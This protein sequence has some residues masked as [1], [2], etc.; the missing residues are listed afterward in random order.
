MSLNTILSEDS[1]N[2]NPIIQ[3]DN[4]YKEHLASG[5]AI[6]NSVSLGTS[7]PD[8]KVSLRTVL[9]KEYGE[10][11][12]VF[13]TNYESKKGSQLAANPNVA[14]LF[15]WHESGRQVRIEGVAEKISSQESDSY[16]STRPRESQLSAWASKQSTAVPGRHYLEERHEYYKQLFSDRNVDRPPHWGGFL[17]TPSWFEFWQNDERRLHDR[18]TYTKLNKTWVLERLAP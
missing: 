6:P 15:Y 12:F 4:W 18:L 8:G 2:Q 16:F 10:N 11:G 14:L 1:V 7:T 9:L 17:I 3:F 13:F 5:V